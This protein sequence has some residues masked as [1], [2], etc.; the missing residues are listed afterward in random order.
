MKTTALVGSLKAL[1]VIMTFCAC[2]GA[3]KA[4]A[5]ELSVY[6]KSGWF[7]WDEK[8]N[9]S[10][11]VKETGAMEGAGLTR[12]DVLSGLSFAESAEVW[13]GNLDYDGHDLTGATEIDSDTSYLGTKEELTVGFKLQAGNALS[14]EPFVGG[15]HRFWVRTLSSED[16]NIIYATA[17]LTGEVTM[18]GCTLYLKGGA[19]MPIYARSHVSLANAGLSDV[20][21]EPKFELSGFAEGGI[22]RGAFAISI[23]FERLNFGQSDKVG[24]SKLSSASG[25][26]IQNS[27]AFQPDSQARLL[28]LKLASS[29]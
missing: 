13:G 23:E 16:W 5:G 27:Q 29:F 20:V 21:T 19:L 14:L 10:S 1:A 18:G 25:A 3:H 15:G 8:V 12:T 17:G 28:S 9:G 24:T 22:K 4:R 7:T 2:S 26:V 6:F 11:F